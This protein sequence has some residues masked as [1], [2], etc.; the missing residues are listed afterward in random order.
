MHSAPG[1]GTTAILQLPLEHQGGMPVERTGEAG[2][3]SEL[4]EAVSGLIE[5]GLPELVHGASLHS[6]P[7]IRV[8]LVDDHQ[9]LRQGLRTIVNGHSR[10]EVVGEAGDGLEAIEL[11]RVF[12]PDVVVMDVNMP[13]CDGVMA[14]KRIKEEFPEMKILALSMHNS[15]DIV[16][17]M[18]QAGA[19][20]YL[21]KESAG[22]QLCRAIVEATKSES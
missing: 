15:P 22:G 18:R 14:T 17:R 2:V 5:P 9:M 11:A 8:L 13:R 19:C 20:G 12:K 7:R 16:E 1:E 3:E 10:L 21:T 4:G 6:S